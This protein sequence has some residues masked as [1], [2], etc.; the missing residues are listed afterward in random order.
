MIVTLFLSVTVNS[1]M[2]AAAGA[3]DVPVSPALQIIANCTPVAK[4]GIAGNEILFSAEDFERMLNLS[5]VTSVTI[6]ELPPATDGELLIGSVRVAKG[7]TVSRANLSLMSYAAAADDIR[8]SGFGFSVNDSP[9]SLTCSLYLLDSVNHS[10][11]TASPGGSREVGTYRDVAAYG[12]LYAYDPEG[13]ALTYQI[14]TYP[15]NG[16]V[17]MTGDD[18]KYVYMP[19][20]G[21]TGTDSLRYVVFDCYGN[22]S[23][24]ATV[25]LTVSKNGTAT[26]YDDMKWNEAYGA[27]ITVTGEGIMSGTRIG[28]SYYFYPGQ[29][30]SRVELLV[31][32]MK[33]AGIESLPAV[34][35]TG[36]ADDADIPA[37]MKPYVGAAARAGYVKGSTVDGKN[38]FL[39]DNEITVA[40][41]AVMAANI[42]GVKYDG[43]I[44]VSVSGGE[45]PAW[46]KEAVYSLTSLG[47]MDGDTENYN[48]SLTRGEAAML[49]ESIMKQSK[50]K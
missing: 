11:A 37:S 6:T 48:A 13:D 1:G 40:E 21:F 17:I 27:A 42:L 2:I 12:R 31:M 39:P 41:A 7:Q 5:R 43:S 15:E 47:V 38:C 25:R 20:K 23:A 24:A 45:I 36:F 18:G 50:D 14:V 4:S 8:T 19:D 22:C 33:A 46:A 30:V 16:I 28:E 29:T 44:A 26:A 35:N 10:P 49:L 3:D 9:Y 34:V 32:A